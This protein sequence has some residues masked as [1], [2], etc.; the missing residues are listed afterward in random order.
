MSFDKELEEGLHEKRLEELDFDSET[1][2]IL[3]A[4]RRAL[5]ALLPKFDLDKVRDG[6]AWFN[7]KVDQKPRE[8][9]GIVEQFMNVRQRHMTD[10]IIEGQTYCKY[11][12]MI[13]SNWKDTNLDNGDSRYE[14]FAYENDHGKIQITLRRDLL[15]E[16][17][18]EYRQGYFFLDVGNSD[19]EPRVVSFKE[20][21]EIYKEWLL[22]KVDL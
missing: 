22:N 5:E 10:R 1:D 14:E 15:E 18:V 13:T 2:Q 11:V 4:D 17:M 21:F 12:V 9:L 19:Q 20:F 3:R 7:K 16:G 6:V 8:V